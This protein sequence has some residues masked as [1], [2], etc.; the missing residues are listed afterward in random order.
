MTTLITIPMKDPDASKTRLATTLS[1]PAR[2][3]LATLLYQRSLEFLAPLAAEVDAT[4]SVVTGSPTSAALA[5]AHGAEVIDEPAGTDLSGAVTTAAQWAAA[6]G[7]SRLCIIPADLVAPQADDMRRFLQS[8]APVTLCPSIDMGTNAL[9]VAPPDAI[10]FH[11][12]KNSARLH[13]DAAAARGLTARLMPLDS[14]RFDLD[15][16]DCLTRARDHLP[17]LGAICG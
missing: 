12:G 9:M 15:T 16:A 2:A 5:R 11:Y 4:L 17:E 7:F 10:P 13:R 3:R 14:L 1:D 6:S 8:T